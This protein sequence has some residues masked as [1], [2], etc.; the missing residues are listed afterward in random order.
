MEGND[1]KI[2]RPAQKGQ[3]L[4]NKTSRNGGER[5][6]RER[7]IKKVFSRKYPQTKLVSRFKSPLK[8]ST[9]MNLDPQDNMNFQSMK[10]K[11]RDQ[12]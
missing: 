2:S 4:N 3:Y 9:L 1:M 8:A 6:V 11:K 5:D 7:V 10:N 12:W